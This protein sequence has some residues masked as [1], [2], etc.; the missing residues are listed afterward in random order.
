[1][2][3]RTFDP[4]QVVILL[5]GAPMSGY[6]DGTFITIERETDTFQKESG[7]DGVISRIKMNDKS[8]LVTLT[9]SQT[10]PSNNALSILHN[11]DELT[12]LGVVPLVIK[13]LSGTS[14]YFSGNAW[15]KKPASFVGGKEFN[16]REWTI[17]C[18]ETEFFTGGNGSIF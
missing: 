5:G 11:T 6:A 7:A 16:D 2:A 18:A 9:L 15:I 3:V 13:D 4:A 1:M 10:S 17:D 14:T 8:T 12:G